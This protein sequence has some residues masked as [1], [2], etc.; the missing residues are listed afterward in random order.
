MITDNNVDF[1]LPFG[2]IIAWV[3]PVLTTRSIPFKISFSPILTCKFSIFKVDII[4]PLS[5]LTNS[6]R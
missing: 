4:K 1:P 2:P 3:S 6:T 5:I